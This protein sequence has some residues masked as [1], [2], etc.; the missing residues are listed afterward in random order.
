MKQFISIALSLV[1]FIS[2]IGIKV[3]K[4]FCASFLHSIQV[5]GEFDE[6]TCCGEEMEEKAG[7][8]T[9]E[10][11]YFSFDEKYAFSTFNFT[12]TKPRFKR[13]YKNH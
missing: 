9:D 12:I 6:E 10:V 8:C 4:H 7:C 11:D 1:I 13:I 3:D 5:F 2:T